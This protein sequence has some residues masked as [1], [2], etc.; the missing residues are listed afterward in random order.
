MLAAEDEE[1]A[2]T[3]SAQGP[4]TIKEE[5][6]ML[7]QIEKPMRQHNKPK[8]AQDCVVSPQGT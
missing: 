3:A 4:E 1:L 7:V 8:K 2:P 6:T 5:L